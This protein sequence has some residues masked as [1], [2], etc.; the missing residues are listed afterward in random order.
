[1]LERLLIV[2][3]G[4]IGSRH[5]CLARALLPDAKTA[6][7]RHQYT[8]QSQDEQTDFT[9]TT[10]DEVRE[11]QP[12]AAIIAN[13]ATCHVDIAMDL[14]K[15]GT[16][17]L[18]EKPIAAVPDQVDELVSICKVNEI[19]LM[20]GYNLRF[21]PSLQQFREYLSEHKVGNVLSVRA[22]VG[23]YLPDWR[24]DAD[25]RKSV[26]AQEKLGGGVLLEL[27]HEIDYLQWL[28]GDVHWVKAHVARHS[29]LEIDV[30][31]SAYLLMG[32]SGI[33]GNKELVVSLNMDFIRRDA[34]RSCVVIG[35]EGSLRWNALAGAVEY[36][37]PDGNKWETLCI[38]AT[39]RDYTYQEELKHF[40]DC[41]ENHA[42]PIITGEDGLITLKVVNAAK[43]S[44]EQGQIIYI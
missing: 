24:P 30:E 37:P 4:S 5:A 22:E 23:Q 40:F 9:F 27:S 42:A 14:A 2:G 21:L 28:F 6:A 19:V 32:L 25:Y 15:S 26:S 44:H 38:E 34:T 20:T 43:K 33:H 41:I 35:E 8:Q 10:M 7:L 31:D 29:Q 18:I 11:F 13:P 16:H 17:L 1:M 12:Q 3:M 39:D 36:F